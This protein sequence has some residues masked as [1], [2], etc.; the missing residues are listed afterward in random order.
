VC[1]GN[2][3]VIFI[4]VGGIKITPVATVALRKNGMRE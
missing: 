4:A 1:V 3:V 2:E